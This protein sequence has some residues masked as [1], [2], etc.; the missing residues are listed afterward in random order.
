MEKTR[1]VLQAFKKLELSKTQL[2]DQLGG[3]LHSVAVKR[4][5]IVEGQDM[6]LVLERYKEGKL[7]LDMLLNWV[8]IVWFTDLFEYAEDQQDCI[9]SVM[10]VLEELDEDQRALTLEQVDGLIDAIRQNRE[11]GS[12]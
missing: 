3:N 9:A 6:I 1:A 4:P 11:Y 2:Q 5:E 12:L 8:N 7:T 10:S